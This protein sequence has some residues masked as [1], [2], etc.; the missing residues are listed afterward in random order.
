MEHIAKEDELSLLLNFS[1][2]QQG[3]PKGMAKVTPTQIIQCRQIIEQQVTIAKPIMV[4]LVEL[5]E[6][7]RRSPLTLQGISTRSLVVA[8]SA[9]RVRALL[10]GRTYVSAEDVQ[11]LAPMLFA[12]RLM[13]A[14]G[15]GDAADVISSCL[16]RP[17]ENLSRGLIR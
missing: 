5:A 13:M 4:C 6:Q 12:H 1:A 15:A 7:T 8:L 11:F 2:V 3:A 17:M 14:P 9:L 10:Q 16:E